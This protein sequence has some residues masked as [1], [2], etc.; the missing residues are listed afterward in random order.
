[1]RG[2]NAQVDGEKLDPADVARTFL[3]KHSL[4]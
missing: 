4:A 2:L 1:M 3:R